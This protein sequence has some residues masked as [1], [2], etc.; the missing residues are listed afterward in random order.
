MLRGDALFY[1][2][3]FEITRSVFEETP[4]FEVIAVLQQERQNFDDAFGW[5]V[6]RRGHSDVGDLDGLR[7][8][9]VRSGIDRRL[10]RDLDQLPERLLSDLHGLSNHLLGECLPANAQRRRAAKGHP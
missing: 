3:H 5:E 1:E 7:H 2:T 4:G 8:E 9:A 10:C 6:I